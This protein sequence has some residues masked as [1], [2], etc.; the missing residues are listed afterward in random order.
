MNVVVAKN[1]PGRFTFAKYRLE[2]KSSVLGSPI[3][4]LYENTLAVRSRRSFSEEAKSVG[5]E[6]SSHV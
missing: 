4:H 3:N 2:T 1:F 5:R 6:T